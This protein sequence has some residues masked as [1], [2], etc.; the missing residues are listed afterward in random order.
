MGYNDT[1]ENVSRRQQS[2]DV[3]GMTQDEILK[4][5]FANALKLPPDAVNWLL[6]MWNLIQVF[7]DVADG[8]DIKRP[9][10]DRA[11][12]GAIVSLPTNPFYQKHQAALS[13]VLSLMVLKWLASDVAERKGLADARSYMWRAE[14]YGVVLTVATLV[15]GPST[16]TALVA[17]RMYGET[18]D[19]YMKE[20]E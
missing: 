19:E 8:D 15:H 2:K 11:I 9:D 6:E 12:Y 16:E 17:L 14:Y 1:V 3:S 4:E 13:P 10:L 20:F 18:A 5:N 7:D